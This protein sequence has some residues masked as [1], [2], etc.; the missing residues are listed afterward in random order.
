MKTAW[1]RAG[2]WCSCSTVAAWRRP[3]SSIGLLPTQW[4]PS[5]LTSHRAPTCRRRHVGSARHPNKKGTCAHNPNADAAAAVAGWETVVGLELHAQV[6]SR[7]KL[8]SGT[9]VHSSRG[10]AFSEWGGHGGVQG[11][12]R[13][14]VGR[15]MRGC[16]PSTLPIPAPCPYTHQHAHASH[17]ALMNAAPGSEPRVCAASAASRSGGRGAHQPQVAL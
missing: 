7:S 4:P 5:S 9:R 1:R 10:Q 11:R 16:P 2:S 13:S 6:L 12:G 17:L 8:F 15:A 3:S 14:S